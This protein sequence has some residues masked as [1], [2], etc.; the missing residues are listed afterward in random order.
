[1]SYRDARSAFNIWIDT[2]SVDI[3]PRGPYKSVSV[4]AAIGYF[5][6]HKSQHESYREELLFDYGDLQLLVDA[7]KWAHV[8][9]GANSD[10]S[11]VNGASPHVQTHSAGTQAFARN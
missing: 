7:E 10:L 3:P 2:I 6:L 4:R 5:L 8:K 9:R 11:L 1:M